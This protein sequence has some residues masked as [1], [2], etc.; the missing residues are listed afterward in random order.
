M[1]MI[2]QDLNMWRVTGYENQDV[3]YM[4]IEVLYGPTSLFKGNRNIPITVS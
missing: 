3:K 2:I 4:I 1:I